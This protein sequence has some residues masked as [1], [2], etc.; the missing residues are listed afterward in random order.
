MVQDMKVNREIIELTD[1][2]NSLKLIVA[3]MRERAN[4]IANTNGVYHHI[5][6][7]ITLLEYWLDDLQHGI[8]MENKVKHMLQIMRLSIWH[9]K[10]MVYVYTT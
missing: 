3:S 4:Y 6:G 10:N 2:E 5:K 8:D 9:V 1:K 7:A